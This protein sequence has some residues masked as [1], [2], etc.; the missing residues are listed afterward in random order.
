MKNLTVFFC[1]NRFVYGLRL[2][3]RKRA[4]R[5]ERT[6]TM[7]A[8]KY[9]VIGR[10]D[11]ER[12]SYI[13]GGDIRH[14]CSSHRTDG[15]AWAAAPRHHDALGGCLGSDMLT[16]VM[17]RCA[18]CGSKRANELLADD[19]IDS[20]QYAGWLYC[21]V[22]YWSSH[23]AVFVGGGLVGVRANGRRI[24]GEAHHETETE[25]RRTGGMAGQD[26]RDLRGRQ[27]DAE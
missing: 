15:A 10:Y 3:N 17:E 1:C 7:K 21:A 14:V 27:G 11:S 18:R 2:D 20:Y 24:K 22:D 25:R 26:E 19:E 5:P 8:Q 9:I 4:P 12:H 23:R 6:R 13:P 16:T